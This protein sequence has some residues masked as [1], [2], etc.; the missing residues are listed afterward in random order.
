M[1]ALVMF[2]GIKPF[3]SMCMLSKKKLKKKKFKKKKMRQVQR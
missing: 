1:V 3:I 2:I